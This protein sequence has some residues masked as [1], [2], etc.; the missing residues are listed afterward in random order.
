[1]PHRRRREEV[2]HWPRLAEGVLKALQTSAYVSIRQHILAG[3]L[4]KALRH[5]A[6]V[7]AEALKADALSMESGCTQPVK[8]DALSQ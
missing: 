6:R 4:L 2:E 7:N 5:S 1:M 3:R 8:A